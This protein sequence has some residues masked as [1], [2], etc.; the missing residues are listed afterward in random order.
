M[1]D[2]HII[3]KKMVAANG[4]VTQVSFNNGVGT[5]AQPPIN[6][7]TAPSLVE[8]LHIMGADVPFSQCAV[9]KTSVCEHHKNSVSDP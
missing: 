6:G 4:T 2:T 5:Q 7:S 1:L 9:Q 8:I 3:Q